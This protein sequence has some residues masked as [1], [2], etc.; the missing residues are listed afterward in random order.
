MSQASLWLGYLEIGDKSS[1]VARDPKLC[2]GK[3]D[4]IYLFNLQRNQFVEY[5]VDIV[6]SKLRELTRDETAIGKE[7]KKAFNKA[8][9]EFTPRGKNNTIIETAPVKAAPVKKEKKEEEFADIEVG[10]DD[11]DMFDD[12]MDDED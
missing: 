2:T 10:D 5:K 8:V 11:D 7:L 3:T 12:D 9:K 6:Q 1:P 4:T